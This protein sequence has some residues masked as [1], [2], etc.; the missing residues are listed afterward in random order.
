MKEVI[1]IL[2]KYNKDMMTV[3]FDMGGDSGYFSEFM[4]GEDEIEDEEEIKIIEDFIDENSG[5]H[6]YPNS[7]GYYIGESGKV[8]ITL[9]E[10]DRLV[11][12]KS[13]EAGYSESYLFKIEM[14]LDEKEL[15]YMKNIQNLSLTF[16][17]FEYD[18]E[19]ITYNRDIKIDNIVKE[20]ILAK[21]EKIVEKY[22]YPDSIQ[23]SVL[24]EYS[25]NEGFTIIYWVYE[26]REIED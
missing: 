6:F 4:M 12:Y 11:A 23:D 5:L 17:E 18:Y 14:D 16:H 19:N 3:K 9:E 7:D 24:I 15:N 21:A 10:D 26:Y 13:G 25:P 20:S 22:D 2:K 8:V 1:E